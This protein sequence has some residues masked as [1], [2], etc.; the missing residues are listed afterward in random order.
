MGLR[1]TKEQAQDLLDCQSNPELGLTV[2]HDEHIEDRRWVSVHLLVVKDDLF[3][4]YWAAIYEQ[5]LTENQDT[6]PFENVEEVQ[7]IEVE[8]VPVT[9]YE[10]RP[11]KS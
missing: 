9:T 1:L 8:K 2:E 3:G 6:W 10:Y 4:R 7:F 11:V 5:G